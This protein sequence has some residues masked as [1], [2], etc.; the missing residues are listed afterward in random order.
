MA[1]AKNGA[2]YPEDAQHQ[3]GDLP[4][5]LFAWGSCGILREKETESSQHQSPHLF[6]LASFHHPRG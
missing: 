3:E 1:S 4:L 5:G 6:T 2:A